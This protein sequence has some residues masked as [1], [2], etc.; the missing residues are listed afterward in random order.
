MAWCTPE[1]RME[2]RRGEGERGREK[3][4]ATHNYNSHCPTHS[5]NPYNQM[6]TPEGTIF[7]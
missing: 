3:V 1:I 2:G 7:V 6:N 4:T 5:G